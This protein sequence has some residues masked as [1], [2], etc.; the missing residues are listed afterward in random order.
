[1]LAFERKA[2]ESGIQR[3]AGVD[4]AGRGP[5]AGP[6]VAAAVF[7]DK[8]YL[9]QQIEDT[10][11]GLTDSKMLSSKRREHFFCLLQEQQL[12]DVGIGI[13]DVA[14]IDVLNILK[15]THLAMKKAVLALPSQPDHVLVDGLPV[16]G[17]PCESENIVKGDSK[18]ISIAAAS[19][20]AKVTRD[21]IMEELDADFP[22]YGFA[23][24]K[25]YGT[26]E[27]LEALRTQGPCPH[28]RRSFA[29]VR[30]MQLDFG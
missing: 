12:V 23:R 27:H 7:F 5:L 16:P 8:K 19:I 14:D 28:H 2:W 1:M 20:I 11:K 13:V 30:Q 6:V 24:N 18:S 15:A 9:E 25:G 29:P 17:F 4:E 26:A 21:R 3:L 22:D 10:L